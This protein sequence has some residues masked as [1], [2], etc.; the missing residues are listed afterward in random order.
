[1]S[2]ALASSNSLAHYGLDDIF[3]GWLFKLQDFDAPEV[4]VL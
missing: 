4:L 3:I 1:V 2:S